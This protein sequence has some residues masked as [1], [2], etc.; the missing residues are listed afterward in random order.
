MRWGPG[1]RRRCAPAGDFPFVA[2]TA[3][4]APLVRH[5]AR[6]LA[7]LLLAALIAA[8]AAQPAAVARIAARS[9]V[10]SLALDLL[11]SPTFTVQ[12]SSS[13]VARPA[14][15]DKLR[16]YCKLLRTRTPG[17]CYAATEEGAFA[18]RVQGRA[19]AVGKRS[20]LPPRFMRS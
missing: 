18:R 12:S 13:R 7:L 15:D 14:S 17:V 3:L 10:A 8:A 16:A 1:R 11:P 9:P 20:S 4:P 5:P 2:P 6:R 19:A